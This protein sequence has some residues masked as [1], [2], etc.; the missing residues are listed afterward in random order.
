V[1]NRDRRYGKTLYRESIRWSLAVWAFVI[2]IDLSIVLAIWAAL[3]MGAVWITLLFLIALTLFAYFKSVLEIEVTQG[4]FLVGPAAIER[5]FIHNFK[6]L[7]SSEMKNVRGRNANPLNYLQI[8]FWV[9]GGISLAIRDPRDKT[10]NWIISSKKS[11]ELI[12][13]LENAE[14]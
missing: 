12:R 8:R 6:N 13:V 5:A 3:S 9:P 14:H 4:W 2:F 10:P 11:G 7:S 1:G